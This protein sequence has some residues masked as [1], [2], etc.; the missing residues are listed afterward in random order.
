MNMLTNTEQENDRILLVDVNPLLPL[1]KTVP[2]ME[3][4]LPNESRRF[5]AEVTDSIVSKDYSR[6]TNA[7][8]EIEERQRQRA[9]D[10]KNNNK[11]WHPRFFT[12]AANDTGRPILSEDGRVAIEK[13]NKHD[14][15]LVQSD[16]TAA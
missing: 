9:T 11:E 2:P 12:E 1:E 3:Q 15:V 4:Q 13:L 10:R 8:Q 16:E 6:A 5:W 14:Y 7:K